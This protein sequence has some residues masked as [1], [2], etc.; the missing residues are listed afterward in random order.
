[1]TGVDA[2]FNGTYNITAVPTTTTFRYTKTAA[3]V[4]ST[5]V[6][7]AGSAVRQRGYLTV[8]DFASQGSTSSYNVPGGEEYNPD[9]PI[10]FIIASTEDPTA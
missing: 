10:D 4:A 3:D 2:D 8:S 7:P 9:L 1:V 5:P 6:S